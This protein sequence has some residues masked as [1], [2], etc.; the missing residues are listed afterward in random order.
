M[1]FEC[2]VSPKGYSLLD[3]AAH[4]MRLHC[5]HAAQIKE[6]AGIYFSL[7]KSHD[8]FWCFS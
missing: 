5:F 6:E 8:S 7:G 3:R 1:L 2:M 4:W